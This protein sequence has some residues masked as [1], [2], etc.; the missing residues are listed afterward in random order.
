MAIDRRTF[1]AASAA[2][3]ASR[4][5]FAQSPLPNS[6]PGVTIYARPRD[7]AD[8]M[9]KYLARQIAERREYRRK[10]VAAVTTREQAEQRARDIR[11]RVWEVLGGQ[12]EKTP[13]N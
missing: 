10:L 4:S 9:Q 5:L 1:L 2:A 6:S 11:A 12:F 13:L 8:D 3:V 7:Y